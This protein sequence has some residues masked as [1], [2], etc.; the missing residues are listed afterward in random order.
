VITAR[1]LN[2]A[3]L[4]RQLLL[5]REPLS[6]ADAVRRIVALQA[7]SPASPY[8]ALWNRVAGFDAADLDAAYADHRVVKASLMRITLH[9]VAAE[10]YPAF[11][12]AMVSS[13]RAARL[14][15]DRFKNTGLTTAD[16]D[17]VVPDVLAYTAEPRT[18][19]EMESWLEARFGTPVPRLWWA[20]RHCA[21][22]VHAPTG[23]PWA[24]GE[25][26]AYVAARSRPSDGDPAESVQRLV[27]RYLEGFGPAT[28]ADIA[29][30]SILRRPVVRAALDDLAGRV[31]V[32]EGPGRNLVHDVPGGARPDDKTEAPPR[33]LGMWDLS[34]L[35]YADRGRVLPEEYRKLVIRRNGDVLPVL[36]VDG[37]VAGVWR[38][39]EGGI[40]ATAFR[41]LPARAWYGLGAEAEAL[42]AFLAGR[43]PFVYRRYAHWW[44][45]LP[46]A[47]VRVLPG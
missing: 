23:G 4:A 9:A 34:L 28:A 43:D 12:N 47:Q 21:P 41:K 10:D 45:D 39:V 26:A 7:Q 8:L 38:P 2:R 14:N 35:A 6:V 42:V 22:V 46:S 17:A 32:L 36:L 19:A 30:F 1:G 3:T 18:N 24:H 44:D 16:A 33:L 11:Q 13:L 37:H 25:R 29:Q 27:W 5:E 40:E 20:L 15:D 31:E